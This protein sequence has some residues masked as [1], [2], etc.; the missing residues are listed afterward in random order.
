MDGRAKRKNK[1]LDS[2][3]GESPIDIPNEAFNQPGQA[4]QNPFFEGAPSVESLSGSEEKL[5]PEELSPGLKAQGPKGPQKEASNPRFRKSINLDM[6]DAFLEAD[7]A[8]PKSKHEVEDP[9][10]FFDHA[11]EEFE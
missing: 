5:S 3:P 9:T 8:P 2:Q 11:E 1:Q 7:V 6:D 10:E 4:G